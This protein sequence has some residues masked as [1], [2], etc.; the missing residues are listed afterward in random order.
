[1]ADDDEYDNRF[2]RYFTTLWVKN[3][4]GAPLLNF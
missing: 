2:D 3:A 4:T 1:M